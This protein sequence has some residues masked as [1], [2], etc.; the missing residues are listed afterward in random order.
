MN[1]RGSAVGVDDEATGYIYILRSLKQEPSVQRIKNLFKIG[2]ST[3]PT[4][5]RIRNAE[6]ESTYLYGPVSIVGEWKCFNMNVQ[7]FESM[8]HRIF[9]ESRLDIEMTAPN[10]D[11]FNPR[12]W[13]VV[14]Q[15]VIEQTIELILSEQV[16]Y[17][18]YDK[19]QERLVIM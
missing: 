13:F 16:L 7:K 19:E 17:Y 6:R 10:G 9:S 4:Q 15:D 2:F 1:I 18:R 3:K 11:C 14:P 5:D 12:E 8:L